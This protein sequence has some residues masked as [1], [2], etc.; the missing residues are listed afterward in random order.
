V[1]GVFISYRRDDS[2][3][4]AGRLADDLGEKFGADLVFMDV[5]GIAPG[6]DFRKA[7]ESKVGDC[8]AVLVVIGRSWLGGRGGDARLQDATDVVRLEVASALRRDVPVIPVL[9]DGATMPAARD[10]PPDVEPLA[11]RNAVELR[12]SRWD[13]DLQVLV[14]ALEKLLPRKAASTPRTAPERTAVEAGAATSGRANR[15]WLWT[16]AAA[17]LVVIVA[18]GYF[19]SSRVAPGGGDPG[20]GGGPGT[21]GNRGT[22]EGG[23]VTATLPVAADVTVSTARYQILSAQLERGGGEPLTLR[24]AIRMT[25]MTRASDNFWGSSFRLLVDDVPMAPSNNLNELVD[26]YSAKDGEVAFQLDPKAANVILQ[27]TGGQESTR[28]PI[29]LKK[30]VDGRPAARPRRKL[31]GPFP[32]ALAALP[33]VRTDGVEYRVLSATIGRRNMERLE[34]KMTIRATNHGTVPMNFWDATFRLEVDGVPRAPTSGLNELVA[35]NSA[36]EGEVVF[37]FD[38]TIETL[39]LLIGHGKDKTR[40]PLDLRR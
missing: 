19:S 15:R 2:A 11:W 20:T 38:D 39:A 16:I 23:K 31:A 27:V 8:D 13:A 3:G 36:G 9:V 7:I 18:I 30:A 32:I 1:P 10:L 24:F 21:G 17:A 35:A 40:V 34:L 14:N 4:F 29:D 28:I 33:E 5:T 26:G 37:A 6:I 25:N 12:H 22:T